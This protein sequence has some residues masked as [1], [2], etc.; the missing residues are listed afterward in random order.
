MT[1]GVGARR[2][3]PDGGNDSKDP[4]PT[5]GT[6]DAHAVGS[7]QAIEWLVSLVAREALL[8]VCVN[9]SA[10]LVGPSGRLYPTLLIEDADAFD[11]LLGGNGLDDPAEV[12]GLVTKHRLPSRA[13]DYLGNPLGARPHHL[14]QVDPL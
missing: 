8:G 7:V 9:Q 6:E 14:R 10:D 5:R 13:A 2:L 1:R 4:F 11:G 12:I 3:V